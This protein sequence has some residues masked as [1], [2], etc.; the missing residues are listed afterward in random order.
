MGAI[1]CCCEGCLNRS[2][3]RY[4]GGLHV[5]GVGRPLRMTMLAS[6]GKETETELG[7]KGM[8]S[9]SVRS[10]GHLTRL[11]H[12]QYGCPQHEQA[13]ENDEE[14]GAGL[15]RPRLNLYE[16]VDAEGIG[17]KG[18][19]RKNETEE[20]A[21]GLLD[22]AHSGKECSTL[23]WAAQVDRSNEKDELK[24]LRGWFESK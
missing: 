5:Q 9:R 22:G 2:R 14:A 13:P 10:G 7:V 20:A 17:Q 1:E 24:E 18:P 19:D 8:Y 11:P 16:E 4:E 21:L 12:A 15:E 6:R 23:V 3:T